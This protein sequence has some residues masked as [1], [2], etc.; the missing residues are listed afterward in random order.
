MFWGYGLQTYHKPQLAY[1]H[2]NLAEQEGATLYELS[3]CSI[4]MIKTY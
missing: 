2:T 4:Q 1:L 3:S